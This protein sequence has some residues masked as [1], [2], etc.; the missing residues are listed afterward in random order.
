MTV[1][2][3]AA[4]SRIFISYRR[5]ETA[6]PAGWL[7]GRLVEHFGQGQ[8]FKDVDS[9]QLGDDFVEVIT[10]A[11]G[12]C[13][14]LLALIGSQWLTITGESGRCLDD[15][16]DFVRLEIEAALTR[17]VRVI[18]ILV[19]GAQMPH[20]AQLPPSLAK[21]VRRHA[22]ELSPS[23]F[24]FDI[25]Q[26]LS[27]LDRSL[28]ER[29]A[30]DDAERQAQETR[31]SEER[32]DRAAAGAA[33]EK[34][35]DIRSAFG[36]RVAA[37]TEPAGHPFGAL[38]AHPGKPR[39][40]ISFGQGVYTVAWH[41]TGERVAVGGGNPWLATNRTW[42]CE[43]PTGRH[44]LEVRHR[45]WVYSVAFSP[46]GTLVATGSKDKTARIW[47]AATGRQLLEVRHDKEVRSVTFG[48]DGTLLAT[49][50]ADEA[51]RIWDAS[52]DL[53]NLN[54]AAADPGASPGP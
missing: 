18:P 22:L 42:I 10:T 11:V 49:G 2:S 13:D 53:A 44:L 5:E 17:N 35:G 33:Y 3:P 16:E 21:L 54:P 29:E 30:R 39:V 28:A 24:D 12:K 48:P 25:G 1:S 43:I 7:F 31:L 20:A 41:P 45:N 14:V 38:A 23:R 34:V 40:T 26:L 52:I 8:V 9:I 51:V 4:A 27:V 50:S 19:G 46:D 32:D 6:Y 37:T 15:P 36:D 47:D